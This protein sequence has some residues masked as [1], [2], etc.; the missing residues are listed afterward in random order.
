MIFT[1]KTFP[2]LLICSI[3][4]SSVYGYVSAGVNAVPV[5]TN[6]KVEKEVA[7]SDTTKPKPPTFPIKKF[8]QNTYEELNTEYP[9]DAP[10]PTNVKSV[11]EYDAKSGSYVLRTFVGETEIATPFLMTEQEYKTFSAKQEMQKYW[12]EKNAKSGKNNEDK[13]SISDMK[14][15][16]GAADKVFGPG[17]VQIKTQGSAELIFGFKNNT[18]NNPALTERMR[19]SNIFDFDEK[20]QLNVTGQVGDKVNFAL[21]YNT[22]SSFDF[23]QKMVKLAYKGKEDDIIKNIEAGNVSMQLNS[24]LISGSTALFGI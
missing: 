5:T 24:S 13:F 1:K 9:M 11:V 16:I 21:N 10:K 12:K 4:L 2:I 18:I 15:N 17:G 23:D 22:E 7:S 3:I 20:I 14:F 6:K 19:T 8:T